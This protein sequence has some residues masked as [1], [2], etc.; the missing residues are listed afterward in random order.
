MDLINIIM[1][2]GAGL[3][4][5]RAQVATVSN[6]IANANTPGYSLEEAVPTET[7][8]A[9]EVGTNGYLG[10]GVSLQGV[11]QFRD[12]FVESQLGTAFSN[13]SSTSA[14]ANA[15]STV[16]A[17][18]PQGQ[19]NVTDALGQFYSA[20]RDL[21]QNAGDQGL[22]S[23]LVNAAQGV[24]TA[25]HTAASALTTARN[26][27]DQS[28]SALTVQVN[29]L[30]SGV[31]TL[32][33]QIALSVNSGRTPNDLLD[34]RQ[35]DLDQL[36]QLVGATAV[37]DN[38]SGVNVVLPGGT[39]LVSGTIA[40]SVSV[41]SDT[42]NGGHYDIVLSPA[43][44][45][46]S[47]ALPSGQIGG[48]IGGLLSARDTTLGNA[49][50]GLDTLAYDFSS[51]VNQQSELGYALD[52][53]TGHDLFTALPN[54]TGAAA[55]LTVDASASANPSLVAAAG[56]AA[57]GPGDA[58]NLQAM[59]ATETTP[60]ST[61]LNVQD[62]MAKLTSD[63]GNAVSTAQDSSTFDQNILTSLTNARASASG[64][65]VDDELTKLIQAQNAYNALTKVVTT[66]DSMLTTL[67]NMF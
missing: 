44:G 30:L 39:C 43:D 58:T 49:Q 64:V 60:L 52:G 42:T 15:L 22:R 26:G 28:V 48:Q 27:I 11:V 10:R 67:M 3:G 4:V 46:A 38:H 1:N 13:S 8:P 37:P 50:S 16:T 53:T 57:A 17:L 35:N 23:A 31:A 63:F 41:Q 33:S 7:N 5:Y 65:S 29:G 66:G 40:S 36:A 51:A 56:S 34:A 62:G 2:A 14:Q 12:Q 45:S 54:S 47:T 9:E 32:N 61:G 59:I 20:L 19:G 24:C 25:F 21:N 18:N 6:N 55:N